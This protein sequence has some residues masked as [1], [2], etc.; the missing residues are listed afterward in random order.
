M[1]A[2][3]NQVKKIVEPVV[4]YLGSQEKPV[5]PILAM[6]GVTMIGRPAVTMTG[7]VPF[8]VKLKTAIGEFCNELVV[9]PTVL[10]CSLGIAPIIANMIKPKPP[11]IAN[12]LKSGNKISRVT[13][14]VI[15]VSSKKGQDVVKAFN[16][17][18]IINAYKSSNK[19]A[20]IAE[21][22]AIIGANLLIPLLGN[23]IIKP[24]QNYAMKNIFKIED[25][26]GGSS[27]KPQKPV[28]SENKVGQNLNIHLDSPYAGK[29]LQPN[30]PVAVFASNN[31]IKPLNLTSHTFKHPLFMGGK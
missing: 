14:K 19:T 9:L 17:P 26:E 27:T 11:E 16:N 7:D 25:D 22:L 4:K 5:L 30:K 15:E 28:D 10:T 29:F 20:L 21:F 24:I 8:K 2:F 12:L 3:G 31:A 6:T 1:A 18:D 23:S 13:D